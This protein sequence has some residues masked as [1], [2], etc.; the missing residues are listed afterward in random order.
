M[1]S[2]DLEHLVRNVRGL[3]PAEPLDFDENWDSLD[4]LEILSRLRSVPF[5]VDPGLD[6]S[7]ATSYRHLASILFP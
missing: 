6:L 5:S 2:S 1:I 7:E 3:D 4:H